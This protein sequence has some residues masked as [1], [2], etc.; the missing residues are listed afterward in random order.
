MTRSFEIRASDDRARWGQLTTRH[1]T[2]ETPAFMPVG[3]L[4]AVKGLTP[5]QLTAVGT[6]ILLNNLYHLAIRPGIEVIEGLGGLHAFT[7]WSGPLLTDSGGFQIYSLNRLRVLDDEGV[8]FRSPLDGSPLRL[9]PEG[10]V[11]SQERIGVDIAMMLDECP[12]WPGCEEAIESALIRTNRWAV[13]A[14]DAW[15]PERV[16]LFGI[17]QGGV[18]ERLRERGVAELTELD[19][20]GYA[21]GGVS[22]GE[23]LEDRRRIVEFTTPLLPR[24]KPRYLM[25]VGTPI[26]IV[27]AVRQGIDLFD[28]VLPSRNAR[29]GVLFTRRGRLRIKNSGFRDDPRPVE[30]GC[31]CDCCRRVSRA[32]LH[33]LLRAG[34]M[35]G[36]V[37]ATVHNLRFYLDFIGELREA[38]ASGTVAAWADSFTYLYGDE[39]R[40]DSS[41]SR[42][43]SSDS[44]SDSAADNLDGNPHD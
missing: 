14:R 3:T 2:V 11:D 25:G 27:H 18:H 10:V 34:E 22:V 5:D 36:M 12:P 37:L 21:I 4:G 16:G 9:T 33:H 17:V 26:D 23:P 1:G 43:N 35:T 30:E 41:L 32:F 38:I 39:G 40:P 31:P 7:G 24:G 20:S 13:R 19:F 8:T 42:V 15:K 6:S 29:H 44:G 28:C